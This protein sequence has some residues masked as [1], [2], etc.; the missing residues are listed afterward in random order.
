[1]SDYYADLLRQWLSLAENER[2][3]E[4]NSA[5]FVALLKA[6]LP[7]VSWVGFY[8]LKGRDLVVGAYQGPVACGRFPKDKGVCGCAASTNE[9]QVVAD[10]HEFPGH[11]ACD[12]KARSELVMP[13]RSSSGAVL[14][15]LDLDSYTPG[16][17]TRE[18]AKG[19]EPLLQ[20]YVE[21]TDIPEF[22]GRR[23]D[24]KYRPEA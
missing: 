16:R 22:G 9:T 18:D 19:L 24:F 7:D 11:I 5:Q 14:G 12:A 15:V 8:W 20:H 2:D 23:D 17:F 6:R 1:M 10:V 13:V 4:A 21:A 3:F